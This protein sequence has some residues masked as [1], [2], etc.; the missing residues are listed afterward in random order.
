MMEKK[1]IIIYI[2]TLMTKR[3]KKPKRENTT[4]LGGF[5]FKSL[6]MRRMRKI[7]VHGYPL[8]SFPAHPLI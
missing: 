4:I 1:G 7:T 2:I 5:P 6:H 8:S 3:K